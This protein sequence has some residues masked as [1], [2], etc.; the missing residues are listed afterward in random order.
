MKLKVDDFD[1]TEKI[2]FYTNIFKKNQSDEE[3]N[4]IIKS[5]EDLKKIEYH[6]TIADRQRKAYNSMIKD[7]NLLKD[8]IIIEVCY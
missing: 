4:S 1:I 5:L 8:A 2:L 7:E 6:R 3:T